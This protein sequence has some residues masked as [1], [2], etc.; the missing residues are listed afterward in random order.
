MGICA[1]SP[2][3]FT[4]SAHPP[5]LEGLVA[6]QDTGHRW[7]SRRVRPTTKAMLQ[8]C[9]KV[10]DKTIILYILIIYSIYILY[11]YTHLY[12]YISKDGISP[13]YEMQASTHSGLNQETLDFTRENMGFEQ[14]IIGLAVEL[15]NWSR[16]AD[17]M[18]RNQ[19]SR[20]RRF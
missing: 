10:W 18:G 19:L 4:I 8:T 11:I 16:L 2:W 7:L 5:I 20:P 13:K 15:V 9:A 14:K 17:F 1:E 3:N 12:V 6:S